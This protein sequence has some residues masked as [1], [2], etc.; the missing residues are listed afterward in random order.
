[1]SVYSAGSGSPSSLDDVAGCSDEALYPASDELVLS[2]L[3]DFLASGKRSS[4]DTDV[5]VSSEALIDI[6]GFG[7]IIP[8]WFLIVPSGFFSFLSTLTRSGLLLL[9][10]LLSML[11]FT[12]LGFDSLSSDT[13]RLYLP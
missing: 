2:S 1:M 10:S 12:V 9:L 3:A 6:V 8:G 5:P 13:G 7:T 11:D 4:A